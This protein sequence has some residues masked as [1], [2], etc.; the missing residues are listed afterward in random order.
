MDNDVELEVLI[1]T[2]FGLVAQLF[3]EVNTFVVLM[4]YWFLKF[5]RHSSRRSCLGRTYSLRSK[6]HNVLLATP[7]P[8]PEDNNDYRWKYFKGC[9]GALDGTY[10]PVRVPHSDIPRYRI[11]KWSVSVNVL[12]VCDQHMNLTFVLSGLEGSATDSRVLRDAVSRPNGLR[13]PNGC[14]YLCDCGY[15]NCNGFLAP[16]RGV[17]YHLREWD[18]GR[19]P[20]NHQEYFNMKHAKARNCIERA[21]GI[22]K[23]RWEI[24]RSNSFYPIK[25]QN[26][27][28]L[29]CYLLHNFIQKHM[30]VDPFEV[31]VDEIVDDGIDVVAIMD[32]NTDTSRGGR[33]RKRVGT[34]THRVWTFAEECELMNAL[35]ELVSR[36][37][38][39]DNGFRSGY[40]L[41]LENML[42][43]KFPRSDLKAL[44]EVWDAQIK[45]DAFTKSL[46]N[47]VF[48]FYAAWCEVFDND[49]AT[50]KDSQ[51]Y[52]DAVD[53]VN[54]SSAKQPRSV[55]MDVDDASE[56]APKNADYQSDKTSFSVDGD[57]SAPKDKKNTSKRYKSEGSELQ[58]METVGNFCDTSKSTFGKIAETMGNIAN[59]VG[60]EFDNR[61]RRDQVYDSLSE[62]DFMFVKVRVAVSQYLCNNTKDMDLFFIVSPVRRRRCS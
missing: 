40:L 61:Q 21:F 20:H 48:P 41:L 9:L 5:H 46:K 1:V 57:S 27:F 54:R 37:N 43:L 36:G 58:F 34:T 35:K 31:D 59:R 16:Y 45:V 47:K 29:G 60:S 55:E 13:V 2:L 39:C 49:T 38:K 62:M 18:E 42:S 56:Y 28:I 12:A 33:G 26:R 30:V 3:M 25:T 7:E 23:A 8:I 14:Y 17:R 52:A 15:T 4:S 44:P 24:L 11:R 50:S 10:I 53:E 32:G 6:L 19:Q 22:L 51:L